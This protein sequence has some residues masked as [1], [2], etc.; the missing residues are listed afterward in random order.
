[1]IIEKYDFTD[2]FT[3]DDVL[4]W[5]S[6]PITKIFVKILEDEIS[7]SEKEL[8]TVTDP[9]LLSFGRIQGRIHAKTDFKNLIENCEYEYFNSFYKQQEEED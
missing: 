6:N 3:E 4:Q 1:M 7:S 8:L 9:N 5:R 2:D